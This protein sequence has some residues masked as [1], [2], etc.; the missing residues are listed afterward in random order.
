MK[1]P[2]TTHDDRSEVARPPTI[3]DVARAAGV[4]TSTVSRALAG[5]P[6]VSPVTRERIKR[7]ADDL[8]YRPSPSAR[9]LRS[10]RTGTIGLL[11]PDL[12]NPVAYD[13]LRATVQAALA[14]GYTVFVGDGQGSPETQEAELARMR[15][16]RVDGLVLGRGRVTVTDSLLELVKF[17]TP[18]EPPLSHVPDLKAALGSVVTPYPERAE[19]DAAAAVIAYRHLLTLG[20]R[21]FAIFVR[22]P[23]PTTMTHARQGALYQVI[24]EF[25]ISDADV[26]TIAIADPNDSTAEVQRLAAQRLRPTAIVSAA[27]RL[28]PYLLE[29]IHSAALHVPGDV[30]FLSFGDSTWHRAY[31]PPISVIRHDYRAAAQRSV[32]RLVARIEG[33]PVPDIPRRPSEFVKRGSIGPA[34]GMDYEFEVD[35]T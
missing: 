30:S 14:T 27:G 2:G 4:A 7:I 13:H 18:I 32:E 28:T 33:R 21:R 15:K 1:D 23:D 12:Q 5:E 9:S 25:G 31:S 22:S 20:H 3:H 8:G 19:L 11:A 34:P 29:G 17:G 35:K 26:T 6:R 24:E 16:Y 10:A